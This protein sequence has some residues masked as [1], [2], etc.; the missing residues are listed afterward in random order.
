MN[1]CKDCINYKQ[2][3]CEQH[4]IERGENEVACIY[5]V[6]KELPEKYYSK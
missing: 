6:S 1:H 3:L 5:F 4:L 2:G